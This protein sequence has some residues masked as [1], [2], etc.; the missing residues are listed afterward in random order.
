[1]KRRFLKLIPALICAFLLMLPVHAA[2]KK[3][4]AKPVDLNAASQSELE[5]IP[6]VG[7]ATA[8]K[9]I[10]G[11][12][13]SSTKDL[14]KSGLPAKTIDAISPMVTVGGAPAAA[15]KVPPPPAAQVNSKP[16]ASTSVSS[17]A[18]NVVAKTPPSP[19]MVWVNLETKVYHKQGDRWYGK[20]RKGT[21]MTEDDAKRAGYRAAK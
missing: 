14:S 4:P 10:A 20:T 13:Y 2:E 16:S 1:M 9:I 21:Y 5:A 11:R 6:G 19:G 8:K 3:A 17:P 15:I 12:P 18:A 7:A